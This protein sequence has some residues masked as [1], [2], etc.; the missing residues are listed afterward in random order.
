MYFN[1]TS[2]LQASIHPSGNL[3]YKSDMQ[4]VCHLSTQPLIFYH[5][6]SF[7]QPASHTA[8]YPSSH[9][10]SIPPLFFQPPI[11]SV[12]YLPIHL[13]VYQYIHPSG[14]RSNHPS[15]HQTIIHSSVLLTVNSSSRSSIHTAIGQIIHSTISRSYNQP[16]IHPGICRPSGHLFS[17]TSSI[18]PTSNQYSHPSPSIQSACLPSIHPYPSNPSFQPAMNPLILPSFVEQSNH[19]YITALSCTHAT[20]VSSSHASI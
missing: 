1:P 8:T 4:S 17:Y 16:V 12:I 19:P 15:G 3:S 6:Y 13:F 9:P 18:H 11:C 7:I 14:R 5:T 10:S 2:L 20:S